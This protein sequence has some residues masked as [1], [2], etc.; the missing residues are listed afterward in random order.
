[1]AKPEE[2]AG[3]EGKD[4]SGRRVLVTG[5][6]AGI[7]RE[8]AEGLARLGA[9][10][11]LHGRSREKG[12][13]VVEELRAIGV[14]EPEFY[15]ADFEEPD[16]V[17]E[18]AEEVQ[19]REGELDV[20]VNNAGALYRE[21]KVT[22]WGAE[23]TFSVNHLAPFLLTEL[24]RPLVE[25]S[26]D[27]R[28]VTVSSAA[29]RGT[30]L[31]LDRA[32]STERYSSWKAYSMSK[33]ANVMHTFE[34]ARRL[35]SATANCLHPGMIPGSELYRELPAPVKLLF[36]ILSRVPIGPVKSVEQGAA[37]TVYLVASGDGRRATGGYYEDCAEAEPSEEAKDRRG[38]EELWRFSERKAGLA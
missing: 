18:L 36:G 30:E 38:Q 10:V 6:T 4:L 24:L 21:P 5:G 9:D 2:E 19:R 26:E 3:I 35:E 37:T 15:R 17:V 27:G 20:L 22:E 29:H 14:E 13:K 34:L 1:M 28:V 16:E 7:G 25:A 12:E 33:L 11:S 23:A 32:T 31:D 8:A